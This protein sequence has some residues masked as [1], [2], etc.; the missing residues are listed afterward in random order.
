MRARWNDDALLVEV[1]WEVCLQLGGIYTVLRTKAQAMVNEWGDNYCLIGPYSPASAGIEFEPAPRT[2]PLGAACDLLERE[3]GIEVYFGR[4]LIDGEPQAVLIDFNQA[5][6]QL[7]VLKYLMWKDH[8]IQVGDEREIEDCLLFGY[9]AADF[10]EMLARITREMATPPQLLAQFHEWMAGIPIPI[11]LK[12]QLP[13]STIFTTHATIL[14][15]HLAADDPNFY[16]NLPS[17]NPFVEAK[18]RNIYSRFA[19]ERAAA[20]GATCF[21]TISE[22]TSMEAEYFLGRK[23]DV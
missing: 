15:R 16:Q 14:G 9:L 21:T 5:R 6:S 1:G 18:R 11:L 17:V 3:K 8:D 12:R 23:A 19:I 7:D 4:W 10:I 22:I 2:G 20:T 13:V